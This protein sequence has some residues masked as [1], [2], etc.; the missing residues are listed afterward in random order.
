MNNKVIEDSC[1]AWHCESHAYEQSLFVLDS[2]SMMMALSGVGII[3]ARAKHMP[4][5]LTQSSV[6]VLCGKWIP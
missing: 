5:L 1:D 4:A 6:V 2:C 3:S